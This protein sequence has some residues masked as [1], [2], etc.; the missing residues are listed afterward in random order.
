MITHLQTENKKAN[1]GYANPQKKGF[2]NNTYSYA[3]DTCFNT[4]YY[5]KRWALVME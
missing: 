4:W 2:Y 5:T 3:Y 1:D